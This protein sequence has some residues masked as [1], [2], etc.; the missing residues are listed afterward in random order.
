VK[1]PQKGH[2]VAGQDAISDGQPEA[3]RLVVGISDSKGKSAPLEG[4]SQVENAKHFHAVNETAYSF[5]IT[6]MC[7]KFKLSM[8]ALTIS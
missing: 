4:G 1:S 7:R 2:V 6:D 3:H 8:N 5:C